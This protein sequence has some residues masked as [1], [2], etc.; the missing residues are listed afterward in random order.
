MRKVLKNKVYDTSTAH[1]VARYENN[2]SP[3]PAEHYT[4]DLYRK[5][6]GEFFLYGKGEIVSPYPKEKIIPMTVKEAKFWGR[7]ALTPEAFSV[8]F[9]PMEDG[10]LSDKVRALRTKTHLTQQGFAD[11]YGI[12]KRTIANWE[13]GI[14]CPPDYVVELLARCVE[15]D[16][17]KVE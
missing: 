2:K 6:T 1:M 15:H 3:N 12:P 14:S 11:K 16:Y 5:K 13:A 4:E 17:G 7:S 9:R 8:I 10:T